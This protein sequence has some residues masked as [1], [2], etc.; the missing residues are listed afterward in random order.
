VLAVAAVLLLAL[1]VYPAPLVRLIE[2]VAD[3]LP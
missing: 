2:R 1:G 3:S